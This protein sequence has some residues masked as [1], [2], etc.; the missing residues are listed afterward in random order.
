MLQESL[1]WL[2]IA[3]KTAPVHHSRSTTLISLVMQGRHLVW[4]SE[5]VVLFD[6]E[7]VV[8]GRHDLHHLTRWRI[9]LVS[10]QN[11]W[12]FLVG[13]Q[14]RLFATQKL[15]IRIWET[16]S[17]LDWRTFLLFYSARCAT[18]SNDIW[19]SLNARFLLNCARLLHSVTLEGLGFKTVMVVCRS[20]SW[21]TLG[22]LERISYH[23]I[24]RHLLEKKHKFK[25]KG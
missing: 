20:A 6:V 16:S 1:L 8:W 3:T 7:V 5:K 9:C 18:V 10:L 13:A 14:G 25:E 24:A 12:T 15:L 11:L 19:T 2:L 23:L 17:T 22:C 4:F 21:T